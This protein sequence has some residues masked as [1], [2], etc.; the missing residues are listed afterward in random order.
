MQRI[1]SRTGRRRLDAVLN[2]GAMLGNG[3]SL[4]VTAITLVLN[5][6]KGRRHQAAFSEP[7]GVRSGRLDP[8]RHSGI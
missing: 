2:L 5:D 8:H 3:A 6:R 1:S 4:Y 7:E